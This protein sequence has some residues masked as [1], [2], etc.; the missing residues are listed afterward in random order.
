MIIKTLEQFT[1]AIPTAVAISDFKDVEPYVRSSEQ[2]IKNRILGKDLYEVIIVDDFADADLLKLCQSVIANHAFWD[3]A[4]FL[5][6]V[7]TDSGFAVISA[8]NKVPAS[9][10]RVERLREQC[11]AR[12]DSEEELLIEFLEDHPDYH[13]A[14]KGSPAYSVMTDCLIRTATELQQFGNWEGSR[15]DFLKLRP[16]LIHETMTRL[17][18]VFSKNY[19][20]ELIEK[21]RDSDVTSGDLK[22]ITLLKY[23]LGCLVNG[24]TEA[25]E[26]I[27]TDALRYIDENPADFATYMASSEYLARIAPGYIN[28]ADSQIFNSFF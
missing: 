16:K 25:A 27:A 3:A 17:E 6:L 18:P 26:K 15:R 21:Q 22:V 20:D 2:R 14:W 10:E 8:N 23:C 12:R 13:D 28:E 11:L 9:K 4:P 24:N 7:L 5:D 1:S 19:I